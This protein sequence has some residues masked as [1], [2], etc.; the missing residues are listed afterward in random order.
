LE[1]PIGIEEIEHCIVDAVIPRSTFYPPS[2]IHRQDEGADPA[3]YGVFHDHKEA[4]LLLQ[5]WQQ[6]RP[7]GFDLL[8]AVN[9]D[10]LQL[11]PWKIRC[12]QPI[13]RR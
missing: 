11:A 9:L 2:L 8:V 3:A 10:R 6:M 7:F 5:A 13:A 4:I 12:R 1:P